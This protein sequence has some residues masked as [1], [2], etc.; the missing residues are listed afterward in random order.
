MIYEYE[1]GAR[2]IANTRQ[3]PN[4]YGDISVRVQGTNGKAI[5]SERKNGMT[6]IGPKAW[7]WTGKEDE[8]YQYEHDAFFASIRRGEP[9][10]NGTYSFI[11]SETAYRA[12]NFLTGYVDDPAIPLTPADSPGVPR[13]IIGPVPAGA[14]PSPGSPPPP[15]VLPPISPPGP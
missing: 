9:I 3:I 14:P 2:I 7:T 15:V 4:C 1:N 12:L 10:N 5:V 13:P 8:F 11:R 6:V